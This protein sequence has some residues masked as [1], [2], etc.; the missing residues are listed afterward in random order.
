[1]YIPQNSG[2]RFWYLYLHLLY[3]EAMGDRFDLFANR[4]INSLDLRGY[5]FYLYQRPG[6][7]QKDFEGAFGYPF[8]CIHGPTIFI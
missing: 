6:R 2:F 7:N 8:R 4:I 5:D 3:I 1:M